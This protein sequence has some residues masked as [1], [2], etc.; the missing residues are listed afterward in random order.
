MS[1]DRHFD[2]PGVRHE[3]PHPLAALS[4]ASPGITV[5]RGDALGAGPPVGTSFV[6]TYIKGS[7]IKKLS[8]T[9]DGRPR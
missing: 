3:F 1:A 9:D 5:G 7:M 6:P 2:D 4:G 8:P